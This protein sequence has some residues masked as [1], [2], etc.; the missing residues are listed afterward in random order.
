MG[1]PAGILSFFFPDG[2]ITAIGFAGLVMAFVL[3]FIPFLMIRKIRKQNIPVI[4]SVTGGR[5]LLI[6]FAISSG[7]VGFLQILTMF[8]LLPKW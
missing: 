5:R 2:F 4:Y 3:F 6:I 8:N 1:L 7:A